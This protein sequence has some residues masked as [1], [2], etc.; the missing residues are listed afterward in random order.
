VLGQ[1]AHEPVD[2]RVRVKPLV[3]DTH[4]PIVHDVHPSDGFEGSGARRDRL[5]V[6]QRLVGELH[7][8]GGERMPV[9]EAHVAPQ[10]EGDHRV[11]LTHR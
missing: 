6:D 7:V 4:R 1:N 9:V 8:P 3:D 2:E 10:V 11:V 5:R